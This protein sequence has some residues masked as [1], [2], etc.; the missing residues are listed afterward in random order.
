MA[1]NLFIALN[2]I[3]LNYFFDLFGASILDYTNC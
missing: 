2:K 1:F 3:I